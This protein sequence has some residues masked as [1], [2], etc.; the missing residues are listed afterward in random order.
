MKKN[1]IIGILIVVIFMLFIKNHIDRRTDRL[2]QRI[3]LQKI[4]DDSQPPQ[5]KFPEKIYL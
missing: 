5:I 1:I 4:I 2:I 3:E